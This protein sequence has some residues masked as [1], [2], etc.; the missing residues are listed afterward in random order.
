MDTRNPRRKPTNRVIGSTG[1]VRLEKEHATGEIGTT[2]HRAFWSS[3]DNTEAKR[4]ILR[5]GFERLGLVRIEMRTDARKL[6]SPRAIEK[7]GF[8]RE[9]ILRRYPVVKG[10]A[11]DTVVYS[12]LCVEWQ[13]TVST[14]S[15]GSV[16]EEE[17][18]G[19]VYPCVEFRGIDPFPRGP[20]R[21]DQCRMI[22]QGIK[23]VLGGMAG[24]PWGHVRR[25]RVDARGLQDVFVFQQRHALHVRRVR[26]EVDR[27]HLDDA[28]A[29]VRQDA[30]VAG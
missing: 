22:K 5:F 10:R 1:F 4:L 6:Q 12:L 11:R 15:C 7:L 14:R 8:V 25:H 2:I 23:K 18:T 19:H 24:R 21:A 27:L 28:K 17:S 30:A 13:Q 16:T 3:G 9:G 26:E 20:H 29:S